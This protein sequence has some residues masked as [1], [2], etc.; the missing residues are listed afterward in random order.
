MKIYKKDSDAIARKIRMFIRGKFMN[1]ASL[2]FDQQFDVISRGELNEELLDHKESKELKNKLKDLLKKYVYKCKE[3]VDSKIKV[4]K[5][6]TVLLENFVTAA[7][8][9]KTDFGDSRDSLV[10]HKISKNY[11]TACQKS[12]DELKK[13]NTN[14]KDGTAIDDQVYYKIQLAVD[15]ICGMTDLYAMETYN[16]LNAIK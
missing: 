2:C 8:N 6:M 14:D 10:Y 7:V 5:I 9:G 11:I 15:Q 13:S 1:I 4:H 3:I 12:I 16:V